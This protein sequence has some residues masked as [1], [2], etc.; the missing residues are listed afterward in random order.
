MKDFKPID[1]ALA[2][3]E[4]SG[5]IQWLAIRAKFAHPTKGIDLKTDVEGV[6]L[7]ERQI[8]ERIDALHAANMEALSL[9]QK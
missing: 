1:Y 9:D 8:R 4:L 2:Y 7:E 6:A 3:G 5:K